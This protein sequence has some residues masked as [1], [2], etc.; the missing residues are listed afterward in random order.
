MI[1]QVKN[2]EWVREEKVVSF[3]SLHVFLVKSTTRTHPPNRVGTK[4]S[5]EPI[6]LWTGLFG[7]RNHNQ[8][9]L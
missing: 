5:L 3:F 9:L 2:V 1:Q 8:F 4:F 6:T 7:Q